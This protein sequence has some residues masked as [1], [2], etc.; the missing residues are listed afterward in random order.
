MLVYAGI[1]L[2]DVVS[3]AS[4]C[5]PQWC[6]VLPTCCPFLFSFSAR[7]QLFKCTAFGTS[8]TIFWLQEQRV[9]PVFRRRLREAESEIGQVTEMLDYRAAEPHADVC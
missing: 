6:H 2:G 8:Q 1:V 5:L 7:E 9:D 3:V 4:G